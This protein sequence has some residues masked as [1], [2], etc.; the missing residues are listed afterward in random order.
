MPFPKKTQGLQTAGIAYYGESFAG[1]TPK[2]QIIAMIPAFKQCYF[3][4]KK[5]NA[6][7]KIKAVLTEFNRQSYP[8]VFHIDPNKAS[9]LLKKWDIE[10]EERQSQAYIDEQRR[11]IKEQDDIQLSYTDEALERGTRTLSGELLND[12]MM[13]LKEDQQNQDEMNNND[14]LNRRKYITNVLSSVTRLVHGKATLALK[15]SEEKR[16]NASFLMTILSKATAGTLSNNEVSLLESTYKKEEQ[17]IE[18]Q[19]KGETI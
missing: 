18:Q 7:P 16:N 3:E 19:N 5:N 2:E 11:A 12:A 15:A 14:L 4:I 1:Y 9:K 6:K 8:Q 17:P 13:M 10:F